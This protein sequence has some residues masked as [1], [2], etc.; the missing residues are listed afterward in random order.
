MKTNSVKKNVA[1]NA[2]AAPVK[3]TIARPALPLQ[4]LEGAS[5]I[6]K[7]ILSF[8]RKGKALDEYGHMLACSIVQHV[9]KHRESSLVNKMIDSLA[10]Q[11]RANSLREYFEANTPILC[12]NEAKKFI[13]SKER[14]K[15][16]DAAH[17]IQAAKD[18][19]FY[20][21]APDKAYKPFDFNAALTLLINRA[22]TKLSKGLKEGDAIDPAS[23]AA[24]KALIPTVSPAT[25]Q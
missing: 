10:Q 16:M 1:V 4:L 6:D 17:Y 25:V 19:P 23:V 11:A 24:I 7:G 5:A 2:V 20:T 22:E 8:A 9:F 13:F 3:N 21:F 12:D 14:A 18:N 15:E